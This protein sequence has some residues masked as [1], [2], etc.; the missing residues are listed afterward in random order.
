MYDVERT[1][2]GMMVI[3]EAETGQRHERWPVDAVG[4]L[5]CGE[6]VASPPEGVKQKKAEPAEEAPKAPPAPAGVQ[7]SE[8]AQFLRDR[9]TD[10]EGYPQGYGHDQ[11]GAYVTLSAPDGTPI[12]SEAPS[13][14]WHGEAAAK[15][16]AWKHW[17]AQVPTAPQGASGAGG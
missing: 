3:Y 6:F 9:R 12:K 5:K 16:A 17:E 8:N 4:M 1:P 2:L 7:P 14:K 11:D 15:A 10:D 13:G